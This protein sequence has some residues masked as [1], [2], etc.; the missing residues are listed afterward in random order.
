MPYSIKYLNEEQL[1]RSKTLPPQQELKSYILKYLKCEKGL[2]E[3]VI[4]TLLTELPA[5]WDIHDDLVMFPDASFKSDIWHNL[6]DT[7]WKGI[8][9]IMNVKRIALRSRIQKD[10]FRTPQ[11][12]M[13]LGN[14]VWSF[15]II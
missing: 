6:Q 4:T 14:A 3:D 11:V 13:I 10:N 8:A 12:K 9:R 7:F 15:F 5:K 2:Q 1:L